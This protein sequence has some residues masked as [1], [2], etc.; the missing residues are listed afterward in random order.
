ML[1]RVEAGE[2]AST[3]T[4]TRIATAL[5]RRAELQLVDPRKRDQRPNLAAD[6]VHSLMGEFEGRHFRTLGIPTGLDEPYQHFQFAGRADFVAWRLDE[7]ALLHI[8]NRTRFPDFQE[9]AGSFN[10]KRAYLGNA[11]ANRLGIQRWRTETHVIAALWSAEVLHALRLRTDSFKSLCPDSAEA[12]LGWW[13]GRELTSG[14]ST[15]FV[16]LDPLATARQR[17]W[18]GMEQALTGR[19]RHRGYADVAVIGR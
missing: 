13:Q 7:A 17:P 6:P 16:V 3:E 12:F 9:M 5:G 1:Y 19:P 10:A 14:S 2:I 15:T 4:A 18:I 8:E 11:L